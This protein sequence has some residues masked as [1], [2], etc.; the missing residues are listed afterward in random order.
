MSANRFVVSLSNCHLLQR[1]GL[2]YLLS[3]FLSFSLLSIEL[4]SLFVYNFI[5]IVLLLCW[6]CVW[7]LETI[8]HSFGFLLPTISNSWEMVARSVQ[9]VQSEVVKGYHHVESDLKEVL[10]FVYL[11]KSA[12][13]LWIVLF[14]KIGGRLDGWF[15]G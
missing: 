12:S 8:H 4:Q 7:L 6:L 14:D 2:H 10:T 15:V 11:T 9:T 13:F 5:S 1:S 3:F